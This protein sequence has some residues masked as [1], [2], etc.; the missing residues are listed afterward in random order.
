M[1][2]PY[3]LLDHVTGSREEIM[4]GQSSNEPEFYKKVNVCVVVVFF[5][6][7]HPGARASSPTLAWLLSR[8]PLCGHG[9][10]A[11]APRDTSVCVAHL[12]TSSA[13]RPSLARLCFTNRDASAD[14]VLLISPPRPHVNPRRLVFASQIE[15]PTLCPTS[16]RLVHSHVGLISHCV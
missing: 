7:D 12:I 14:S 11:S 8:L 4:I 5:L 9:D 10:M 3:P 2:F 16:Y 6:T 15:T 1:S 13:H